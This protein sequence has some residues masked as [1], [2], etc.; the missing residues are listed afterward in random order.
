[1]NES[2]IFLAEARE[3]KEDKSARKEATSKR[4]A[5]EGTNSSLK[6]SQGAGRLKVRG[7]VKATLVTGMK[8]IGHNFKQIIRLFNGDIREKATEIVNNNSQG[9]IVPIC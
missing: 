9:A 3:R 4:T 8:I 2:A 6:R 7:K 5:I 1:L